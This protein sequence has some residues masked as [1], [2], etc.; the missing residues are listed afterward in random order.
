MTSKRIFVLDGHPAATSLSRGLAQAYADA[1][2]AAGHDVRLTHLAALDFDVDFG[3]ARFKDAKPL[4]PTLAA[5]RDDIDWCE[6]FVLATPMWWGG[7]PAKLKGL[8]DRVFLPGWAF[9]TRVKPGRMPKPMLQGRTA[10]AF[11]TSD[12]PGWVMRLVYKNALIWK[13]KGQI[14]RFVGF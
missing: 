7:L 12:T 14:L 13:L 8:F 6:H 5:L 10:R 11:V 1:A 4:E 9:D 3:V 2:R